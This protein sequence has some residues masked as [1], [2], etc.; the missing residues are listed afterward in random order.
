M[1]FR[2][3]VLFQ[4]LCLCSFSPVQCAILQVFKIQKSKWDSS[5]ILI[6]RKQL[7]SSQNYFSSVFLCLQSTFDLK[8]ME[9]G[10]IAQQISQISWMTFICVTVLVDLLNLLKEG[11]PLIGRDLLQ[12]IHIKWRLLNTWTG[13]W[14]WYLIRSCNSNFTTSIVILLSVCLS[15]WERYREIQR[16]TERYREIQRDPERY[17]EIQRDTERYR[18][19]QR[20]T[21]R[22][23]ETKRDTERSR[24]IQRDT[25]RY[26]EIQRDL[27]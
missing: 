26:R 20:D 8:S 5:F 3:L 25:E 22:Y 13:F 18:E 7:L 15:V 12:N 2:N 10:E 11:F 14:T 9:T 19:T 21:E 27:L 1:W 6:Q 24:E 4:Y 17:R 23:R 16:D